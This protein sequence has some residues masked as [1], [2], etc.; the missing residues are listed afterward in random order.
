MDLEKLRQLAVEKNVGG[1]IL[2][3]LDAIGVNKEAEADVV[4]E[5]R[6]AVDK[7]GLGVSIPV[8]IMKVDQ[9][10]GA[11]GRAYT[12]YQLM[13]IR[14]FG[15][16]E[17]AP[18]E[19]ELLN[20]NKLQLRVHSTRKFTEA[21][22]KEHKAKCRADGITDRWEVD[23]KK[24]QDY[25]AEAVETLVPG[26]MLNVRYFGAA[27]KK[28][29]DLTFEVGDCVFVMHLYPEQELDTTEWQDEAGGLLR[30]FK[31]NQWGVKFYAKG[32]R[33]DKTA[34]NQSEDEIWQNLKKHNQM[35][36]LRPEAGFG[37]ENQSED[38][39]KFEL[40]MG[41]KKNQLDMW[42]VVM[43]KLPPSDR[44][45]VNAPFV[46]DLYR[47]DDGPS[48]EQLV[49]DY[50]LVVGNPRWHA[51]WTQSTK[52]QD[53][54]EDEWKISSFEMDVQIFEAGQATAKARIC[55]SISA[56]QAQRRDKQ[57]LMDEFGVANVQRFGRIAST[58]V[59][60]CSGT[61]VMKLDL[62]GTAFMM[63]NNPEMNPKDADGNYVEGVGFGCTYNAQVL[64]ID[65]SSGVVRG[66][67]RINRATA[68][69]AFKKAFGTAPSRDAPPK[70][71]ASYAD[72]NRLNRKHNSPVLNLFEIPA[73]FES[74][75][76]E[77]WVFYLVHKQSKQTEVAQHFLSEIIAAAN[78]DDAEV[79][80]VVSE[81]IAD[82]KSHKEYFGFPAEIGT[83]PYD[84]CVFAVKRSVAD[85]LEKVPKAR[86]ED[87]FLVEVLDLLEKKQ[88]Q[89]QS[90]TA[91]PASSKRKDPADAEQSAPKR[92][93][94][95]KEK[96]APP[97][98]PP[99]D[100]GGFDP[101]A[102]MAED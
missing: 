84:Y 47:H 36:N 97:D 81:V 86:D 51:K 39:R 88:K 40:E 6:E 49:D 85:A 76:N 23:R 90:A 77:G 45:L 57:E 37:Q 87:E 34:E 68:E 64:T 50:A 61:A 33:I 21:E 72:K 11:S 19:G 32:M 29:R 79:L 54:T 56:T 27:F 15:A 35:M 100:E 101:L 42:K 60:M 52:L 2:D 20:E 1:S 71:V 69:L 89:Q 7:S 63:E 5:E 53:G 22:I 99:Q 59:P 9:K 12:D 92:K 30:E 73:T 41:A 38:E 26:R 48:A 28:T 18:N 4:V 10:S 78:G 80:R 43:S 91:P 17:V 74:L 16:M 96:V 46:M 67:F 14:G 66:G 95:Q 13:I 25:M 24:E 83:D 102:D 31:P 98:S 3:R 62:V 94:V 55:G 44:G 82:K 65:V 93:K 70:L 58:Y 8:K 75:E